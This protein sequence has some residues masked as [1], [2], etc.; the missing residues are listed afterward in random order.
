M[1][2]FLT[3][4]QSWIKSSL[5]ELLTPTSKM[6]V[7]EMSQK[8]GDKLVKSKADKTPSSRQRTSNL[9]TAEDENSRQCTDRKYLRYLLSTSNCGYRIHDSVFPRLMMKDTMPLHTV[10]LSLRGSALTV[11]SNNLPPFSAV[12]MHNSL[13]SLPSNTLFSFV[14]EILE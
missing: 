5:G 11:C 7:R 8:I 13:G 3:R 2:R 9:Y 12:K 10:R 6:F 14:S 4:I 1:M